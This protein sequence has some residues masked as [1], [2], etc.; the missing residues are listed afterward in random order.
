MDS[1][2][3]NDVKQGTDFGKTTTQYNLWSGFRIF[4]IIVFSGSIDIY[5]AET[6][7]IFN[8]SCNSSINGYAS[9]MEN[10]GKTESTGVDLTLSTVNIQNKNFSWFSDF[11]LSHNREKIKELASGQFKG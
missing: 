4:L 11:S 9:V 10:I 8:E 2:P 7:D 6:R 1:I 5:K 3:K